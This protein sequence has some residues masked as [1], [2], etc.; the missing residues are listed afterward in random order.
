MRFAAGKY[1][2]VYVGGQFNGRERDCVHSINATPMTGDH[3]YCFLLLK[4]KVSVFVS[5]E[6]RLNVMFSVICSNGFLCI[7]TT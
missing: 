6:C 4:F 5:V 1:L 7:W 3:R 2:I